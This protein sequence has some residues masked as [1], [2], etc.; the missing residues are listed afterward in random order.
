M[1]VVLSRTFFAMMFWLAVTPVMAQSIY[2]NMCNSQD[3]HFAQEARLQGC[4]AL[5]DARKTPD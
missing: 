1:N 3:E 5:I 2:E 4:T